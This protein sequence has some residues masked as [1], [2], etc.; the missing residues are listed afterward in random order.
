MIEKV[1]WHFQFIAVAFPPVHTYIDVIE[2][3][4]RKACN[5]FYDCQFSK[6]TSMKG[7]VEPFND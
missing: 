2:S 3:C 7:F 1:T 5:Y 4:Y 6:L